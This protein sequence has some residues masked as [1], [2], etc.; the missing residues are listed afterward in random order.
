MDIG[1]NH[2]YM[3]AYNQRLI[4]DLIRL[5]N[6]IS[7]ADIARNT[8]L[9]APTVSRIVGDLL[10]H[11]FVLETSARRGNLGKPP[12][13]LVLNPNGAYSIGFNFDRDQ[14][15]G[16]LINLGGEPLER[17]QYDL[18]TGNPET[19]LPLMQK[20]VHA[21]LA[22]SERDDK[23][24]L[25]V[26]VGIPGPLHINPVPSAD[27][28]ELP[29]WAG[30]NVEDELSRLLGLPTYLENNPFAAAI[31]ELWHGEGRSLNNFY[32]IFFG[33][34]LGGCAVVDGQPIRGSGGFAAEF[35]SIALGKDEHSPGGV[36]RL[37]H[38]VSLAALYNEL[39]RHGHTVHNAGGLETLYRRQDVHLL[40]WL[41]RAA[42]ELLPELWRL[43]CLFDP[44]AIVF[45]ERLPELL[46]NDLIERLEEGLTE[47]RLRYKPYGPKLLRGWTGVDAAPLGAA[48]LPIYKA[49]SLSPTLILT[50]MEA[51]RRSVA[52]RGGGMLF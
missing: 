3:Q 43:E 48:T 20:A 8:G 52:A 41:E 21:F 51:S 35:G 27:L 34:Y 18:T 38:M 11:G 32:F 46:V 33:L 49:L 10:Q 47:L 42:E 4:L 6:P 14:L 23:H 9:A 1:R 50:R 17:V 29:G 25:G 36:R 40:N 37:G 2:E 28:F 5:H 26:G 45:G 15:V 44:E 19:V 30:I 24:V 39:A 31:G 13:E 16:M 22:R 7:R 12:V